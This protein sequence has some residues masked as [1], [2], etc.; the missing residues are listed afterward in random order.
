MYVLDTNTVAYFFRREGRV[1]VRLLATPPDQVAVPA[2]V[3]YEL[4][5]GLARLGNATRRIEQL[6]QFLS[7]IRVM[8]F[9]DAVAR[10]AASV[11]V[12]LE[13]AGHPIGPLDILIAATALSA[14]GTLITRNVSEFERVSGLQV[15]NWFE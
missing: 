5:F 7:T 15:E 2:I 12:S 8:P 13:R 11:R 14:A 10:L 1:A 4:R 3:A 6:E 9:D